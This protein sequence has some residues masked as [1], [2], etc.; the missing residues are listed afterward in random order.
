[1]EKK[2]IEKIVISAQKGRKEAFGQLFEVFHNDIYYLALCQTKDAELSCDVVQETFV[3]VIQTIQSL[4]QPVAFEKWIK[5]IAYHQCIRH[6]RKKETKHEVLIDENEEGCNVFDMIEERNTEFIPQEALDKEELKSTVLGILDDLPQHQR[7]A[8]MM[9]YYDEFSVKEIA[10]VQAVSP[11]TVLSRLN[12]GRK[13]I[14]KSVEDY[15]KRYQI[16]LHSVSLWPLLY[17]IFKNSASSMQEAEVEAS[18]R[19]IQNVTGISVNASP[20][21]VTKFAK[22]TLRFSKSITAKISGVSLGT[23]IVTLILSTTVILAAII[24]ASENGKSILSRIFNNNEVSGDVSSNTDVE[25][26]E[27]L[28]AELS[29]YD[30][31]NLNRVLSSFTQLGF[32]S[33]PQDDDE[34]IEFVSTYIEH[35]GKT[36]RVYW[37][38]T[39]AIDDT[40]VFW[41]EDVERVLMD[42]FGKQLDLITA[43]NLTVGEDVCSV[44]CPGR[45]GAFNVAIC[46]KMQKN[47][48]GT[49]DVIFDNYQ[50]LNVESWIPVYNYAYTAREAVLSRNLHYISSGKA[51]VKEIALTNDIKDYIVLDYNLDEGIVPDWQLNNWE[52]KIP[53]EG[54]YYVY[55]TGEYLEAG[56]C[57]PVPSYGDVYTDQYYEYT[58]H[59][60]F[61]SHEAASNMLNDEYWN[62]YSEAHRGWSVKVSDNTLEEYPDIPAFIAGKPVLNLTETFKNCMNL[63]R[64]PQIPPTVTV[65][66][67]TFYGCGEMVEAK[68]IIPESVRY[69]DGTFMWCTSL[70]GEITIHATPIDYS[71]CFLRTTKSIVINGSCRNM[72]EVAA[73]VGRGAGY[74]GADNGKNVICG[75]YVKDLD[76]EWLYYYFENKYIS[77]DEGGLH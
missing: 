15:E 55:E 21:S 66:T 16:K 59:Y 5:K 71:S 23:K 60:G 9:F 54:K 61:L 6:Y 29:S 43:K 8:I 3:E 52:E 27:E 7:A 18:I 49:Y 14:K 11:N 26:N 30:L 24:P 45:Q 20:T 28:M 1:M 58:F 70:T 48:D 31:E 22:G 32:E 56:D 44:V 46:R 40:V 67:D 35:K 50:V 68:I 62:N 33:Y 72:K 38:S 39:Y 2:K 76:S 36:G 53:E 4:Q 19:M 73:E 74:K 57:F 65:M 41:K 63:M 77:Y 64:A 37:T 13:A 42:V 75:T 34:M 25:E 69:M 47:I 51:I 10:D 12:Y 17:W